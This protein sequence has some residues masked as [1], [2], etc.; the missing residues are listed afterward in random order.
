MLM[1]E[2]K[3]IP[4]KRIRKYLFLPTYLPTYYLLTLAYLSMPY[5]PTYKMSRHFEGR[6][7][8]TIYR[9]ISMETSCFP[10]LKLTC[11]LKACLVKE[12]TF[13]GFYFLCL[14]T[15]GC[16]CHLLDVCSWRLTRM[17]ISKREAIILLDFLYLVCCWILCV[18]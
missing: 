5:L 4:C 13:L 15:W 17:A 3:N 9:K 7:I 14:S 12:R 11:D 18:G 2:N 16:D 10:Q 6:L 1:L 8:Q